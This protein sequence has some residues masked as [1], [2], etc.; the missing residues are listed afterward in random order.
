MTER[1]TAHMVGWT[2]GAIFAFVLVLNA[3]AFS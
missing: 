3:F 1:Q 2:L